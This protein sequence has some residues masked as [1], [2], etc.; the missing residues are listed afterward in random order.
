MSFF[1]EKQSS[2]ALWLKILFSQSAFLGKNLFFLQKCCLL[3]KHTPFDQKCI[4]NKNWHFVVKFRL[5]ANQLLFWF[6]FVGALGVSLSKVAVR[7]NELWVGYRTYRLVPDQISSIKSLYFQSKPIQLYSDLPMSV[8]EYEYG[9][10]GLEGNL[11]S[12]T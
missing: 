7:P 2:F 11:I 12:R 5:N 4:F 10:R 8:H 1:D 6:C 3:I 9:R